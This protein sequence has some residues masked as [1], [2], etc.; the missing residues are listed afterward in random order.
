[1][2]S[3]GYINENI[4]N[5]ELKP[6]A[7]NTTDEFGGKFS[8]D[9]DMFHYYVIAFSQEANVDI[10]R[11]IFDIANYNLDYYTSTDFDIESV[12][13]NPKTRMI[14]VRSM[15]DKEEGLIYFRSIIRKRNV[16]QSL[17]GIEYVNFVASSTN[18]RKIIEDKDYLEYLRFFMKNYS[19]YISSKIPVDE[20]PPPMELIAKAH[21]EEEPVERGKFIVVKPAMPKDTYFFDNTEPHAF[22]ISIKDSTFQMAPLMAKIISYNSEEQ[23][24]PKKDIKTEVIG[25][26]KTLIIS[27]M[28]NGE[29]AMSYFRNIIQNRDLFSDLENEDYLNFVIS[30]NNLEVLKKKKDVGGYLT[31]FQENYLGKKPKETP[32]I[33]TPAAA[34]V[35]TPASPFAGYNGP[36]NTTPS[37]DNIF[38]LV[39]QPE[40]IK[41]AE[42]INTFNAFN[43]KNFGN[44]SIKVSV[45]PLDDFRS[46]LLISGLGEITSAMAYYKKAA[47]DA[48]LLEALKNATYRDFIISRENLEIFR[49]VKN[50]AQYQDFFNRIK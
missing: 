49:K 21:K 30:S 17:N 31:F 26:R 18:Y 28:T 46:I 50:L 20:L 32:E 15:P 14:V 37:K 7:K 45:E 6:T 29:T 41:S 38:A 33:I 22:I 5:N 19:P 2:V 36:Y 11:L 40:E 42:L 39:F 10:N 4:V 35:A 27:G 12:S 9:E 13:L 8:Y 16:F 47:T 44:P 1:M 24:I 48:S 25:G 43:G 23:E 34:G 3:K